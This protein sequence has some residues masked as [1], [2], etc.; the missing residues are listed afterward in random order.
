MS[1]ATGETKEAPVARVVDL[2]VRYLGARA[3]VEALP[4]RRLAGAPAALWALLELLRLAAGELPA[5]VA[6]PAS[7][8]S[9]MAGRLQESWERFCRRRAALLRE[10]P[11]AALRLNASGA[12]AAGAA[13]F[14]VLD[15]L[16]T[17]LL[18]LIHRAQ[19]EDYCAGLDPRAA[20]ASYR[21]DAANRGR[22]QVR[23][24]EPGARWHTPIGGL[25]WPSA[26]IDRHGMLYTGHADGEFVCLDSTGQVRWRIGDPQM[27]YIDS[28]GALGRDGFLYMAST[29]VDA[30]GHQNQGRIWKIRPDSGDVEWTFWGRHFED[31]ER[32]EQA[33]LSSFFE[34][35]LALGWEGGRVT[36]YA[37]SDDGYL[38]KLADDGQL[39]WEYDCQAYPS[40]VIWTKPLLSPD[41]ATV[42]V[43]DLA[44][45]LHAV[46]TATGQRR[47]RVRLGG[48]VVSSPA[49]GRYGEIFLGCFDGK[50]YALEPADGSVLWTYQ[51]LG[52]I[53][54]SAAVTACGDLVIASS[55]GGVYR[56]D[57]FGRKRWVY[58]SDG[59][60][61]SSPLLD[62]EER[63]YL[64][65][66]SGK[67]Y[68]LDAQGRR[69]WSYQVHPER[70]DND[71][72]SSPSMGPDG[73]LV[74][75][76]TSGQVWSLPRD[77]HL[78]AK[79][80][81]ETDPGHDGLQPDLPPG[82]A[83]VVF[84]DRFGTP[85]FALDEPIAVTD[86][87]NLAFFAVSEELDIVAAELLPGSVQVE[88]EPAIV[89]ELR[90][91]SM[92][93][94]IYIVPEGFLPYDTDIR[95]QVRARYRSGELE[96][97]FRSTCQLR[98]E[99]RP[100]RRQLPVDVGDAI[101]IHGATIC[102]PKEIDA[103]GQAMMDSLNFA[104]AP[105]C[106]DRARGTI[107]AAV[108]DVGQGP[109]GFFYT[110]R[111]VN[112]MV[113][114]GVLRDR[115]FRVQGRLRLVAQGANIPLDSFRLSGRVTGE[116]GGKPGGE[117]CIERGSGY[118]VCAAQNVP[119]FA[120]LV[121]VMRLAD[122]R[123]DV[124]GFTTV[125]SA[126]FESEALLAPDGLRAE[127]AQVGD[128][129]RA[130]IQAP[131]YLPEEHWVQLLLVDPSAPAVLEGCEQ[132]META[133]DGS[134]SAVRV[135]IPARTARPGL[136]AILLL[137]LHVAGRLEVG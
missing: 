13:F 134:L 123:D 75:G 129:V 10:L 40:G 68:C 105:I 15:S 79:D 125:S 127:L 117:P 58:R 32:D 83:T 6:H 120:E 55:D 11:K 48:S 133:R 7:L 26:V 12:L 17:R 110:P 114:A 8:E 93:R 1:P 24:G 41:G 124:V 38:Y 99:P 87:L 74:F 104:I 88:I 67:L 56:L 103:L 2:R 90:V 33:H 47:W 53:Y 44:G 94:F 60:I 52:L 131:G 36:I 136:L 78:V 64:G 91:E 101:V 115:D 72:N 45:H 82:G 130:T 39:L 86:N 18:P 29:D 66:A 57:R 102:Q 59:P 37:G 49:L 51:T 14:E 61:K 106:V 71:I 116:P 126:P 107:V 69:L 135:R 50:V 31:P 3:K 111:S 62:G 4:E 43:G 28:T 46:D 81:V 23:G 85:R 34:G 19:V 16:I 9:P 42:Y 119:A 122:E 132:R 84:M 80:Q 108:S 20:Y 70:A 73:N 77:L 76:S 21:C 25:I 5:L 54:A 109:E 128:E 27:L 96:K 113:V 65:N 35:N 98:S 92:G 118:V 137:D 89:H 30:R 121:R 100:E 22:V 95:V 63:V 97:S 112:K